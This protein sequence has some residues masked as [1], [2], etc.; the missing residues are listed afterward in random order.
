ME[1]KKRNLV[2]SIVYWLSS[3]V[4]ILL[5]LAVCA[6]ALGLMGKLVLWS[7]NWGF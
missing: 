1:D 5:G 6:V 3:T 7:W 2:S 4:F